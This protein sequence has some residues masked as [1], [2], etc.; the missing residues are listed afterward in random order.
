MDRILD[1][2]GA[3]V[4]WSFVMLIMIG[5]NSRMNDYSFESLNTALTQMDAI[6][7]TRI[8]EYDLPKAGNLI[9]GDKVFVADSTE[10]KFLYDKDLDGTTDSLIYYLG[11]T[12]EL[13]ATQN[14]NDRY[15]YRKLNNT[16]SVIGNVTDFKLT[17]LDSLGQEIS[18][19]SLSNQTNR[20]KIEIF[21]VYL[22]KEA[23]YPNY[24]SLY[25]AIEWLRE[26]NPNN[27]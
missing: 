26:I 15:L 24:D 10:L 7:L 18:Y 1:V 17:Y 16:T 20:N 14:T 23:A 21:K 3:T 12:E 27:L 25:P 11:T 9:T 6:E 5:V 4:L 2:V 19:A 22:M 13:S 8:I